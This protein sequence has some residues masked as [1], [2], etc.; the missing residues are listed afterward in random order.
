MADAILSLKLTIVY[1]NAFIAR[2]PELIHIHNS[3]RCTTEVKKRDKAFQTAG[4]T[5][6]SRIIERIVGGG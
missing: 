1:L 2:A 6:R 3:G 5:D 4:D